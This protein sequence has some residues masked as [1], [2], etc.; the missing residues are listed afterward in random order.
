MITA[1]KKQ[2]GIHQNRRGEDIRIHTGGEGVDCNE[3]CAQDLS[4]IGFIQQ[5]ELIVQ[6]P[7][8]DIAFIHGR[9]GEYRVGII[10]RVGCID[11]VRYTRCRIQAVK[12]SVAAS[13]IDGSIGY[14]RR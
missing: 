1:S 14:S 6:G 5:I 12:V 13:D 3:V 7:K 8:I 2:G 11:P 10:P 4:S 9:G